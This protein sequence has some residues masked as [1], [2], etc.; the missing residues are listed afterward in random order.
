MDPVTIMSVLVLAG[1]IGAGADLATGGLVRAE[2]GGGSR[3]AAGY[4]GSAGRKRWRE[5]QRVARQ[6]R[7]QTPLGRVVQFVLD[8]IGGL[9]RGLV[10]GWRSGARKG[11]KEWRTRLGDEPMPIV[12]ICTG[13]ADATRTWIDS[14]QRPTPNGDPNEVVDEPEQDPNGEVPA[15]PNGAGE[16]P[17]DTPNGGSNEPMTANPPSPVYGSP[18]TGDRDPHVFDCGCCGTVHAPLE[19][20]AHCPNCHLHDR[21]PNDPNAPTQPTRTEGTAMT[22]VNSAPAA[23]AAWEAIGGRW[24]SLQSRADSLQGE[25]DSL[26][27][28][29]DTLH[30]EIAT[31]ADGMGDFAIGGEADVAG[32]MSEVADALTSAKE[33][34]DNVVTGLASAKER[35]GAYVDN[36]HLEYDASIEAAAG[37]VADAHAVM[38]EV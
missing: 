13:M 29:A 20:G 27:N 14:R 38:Q 21:A 24:E 22:D 32:S 26:K 4:V 8:E 36:L 31:L 34:A 30:G 23:I 10:R 2:L 17:N 1:F 28:E 7:M 6:V 16:D 12:R 25:W 33:Q 11:R 19:P 3:G 5:S 37:K 15:D 18:A 9:G 35:T